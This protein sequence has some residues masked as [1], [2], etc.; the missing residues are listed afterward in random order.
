MKLFKKREKLWNGK[1]IDD[2]PESSY[3]L[4]CEGDY[5]KWPLWKRFLS[6]LGHPFY[7]KWWWLRG[8]VNWHTNSSVRKL[9]QEKGLH[10]SFFTETYVSIAS[11]KIM[12]I[13]FAF[14]KREKNE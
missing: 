9:D 4:V 11:S 14:T 13:F 8:F 5:W 10:R 3:Y 7:T 6:N 2:F 12:P 1:I